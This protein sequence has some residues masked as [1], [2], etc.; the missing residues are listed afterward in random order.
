M[1]QA[2]RQLSV[3]TNGR[4]G[5]LQKEDSLPNNASPRR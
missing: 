5:V 4:V 1:D 2:G 3:M